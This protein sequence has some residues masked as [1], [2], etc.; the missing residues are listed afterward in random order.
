V[1][2]YWPATQLEYAAHRRH[3]ADTAAPAAPGQVPTPHATHASEVLVAPVVLSKMPTSQGVQGAE[4]AAP[5]AAEYRP[6]A[7]PTQLF[8]AAAPVVLKYKPAPQLV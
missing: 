4:L 3:L 8:D 6:A 1:G 5:V 7:Q 2:W